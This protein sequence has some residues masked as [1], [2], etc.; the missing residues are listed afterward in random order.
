MVCVPSDLWRID[1]VPRLDWLRRLCMRVLTNIGSL[2]M[3]MPMRETV[4]YKNLQSKDLLSSILEAYQEHHERNYFPPFDVVVLVGHSVWTEL[5]H[6]KELNTCFHWNAGP[7]K[8]GS[9]RSQVFG[10]DVWCVPYI[11]GFAVLPKK[12][13]ERNTA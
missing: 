4:E 6:N 3:D 5:L 12:L 9:A 13:F 11:D 1:P 10:V 2:T 7:F 8:H